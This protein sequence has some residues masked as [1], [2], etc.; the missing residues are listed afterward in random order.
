VRQQGKSWEDET[1]DWFRFKFRLFRKDLTEVIVQQ[2][3]NQLAY[4]FG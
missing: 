1:G 3:V 4:G 2:V